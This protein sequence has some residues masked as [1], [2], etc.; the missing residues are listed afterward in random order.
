MTD[1]VLCLQ[2]DE[3]LVKSISLF[4]NNFSCCFLCGVTIADPCN[5]KATLRITGRISV[6]SP[7]QHLILSMI[8]LSCLVWFGPWVCF[9]ACVTVLSHNQL[10]SFEDKLC[11]QIFAHK[12]KLSQTICS[13]LVKYVSFG[14]V[15]ISV[16]H[17][18][19]S[20]S[21]WRVKSLLSVISLYF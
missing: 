20:I 11:D 21:L 17:A 2:A 12:S 3:V 9:T 7:T 10:Q 1:S 18:S 14:P 8:F 4:W 16:C 13:E 19:F 6:V 5:C 15:T